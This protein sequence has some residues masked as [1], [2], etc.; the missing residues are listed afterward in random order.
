MKL[1][2]LTGTSNS[3]ISRVTVDYLAEN[4]T[5]LDWRPTTVEEFKRFYNLDE[6]MGHD[7]DALSPEDI[8]VCS[9][10]VI[11]AKEIL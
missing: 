1:K 6:L 3:K 5:E 9:D 4:D 7:G 8:I 2:A 10:G 11:E